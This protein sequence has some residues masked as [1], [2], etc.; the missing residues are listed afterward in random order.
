MGDISRLKDMILRART[1][2]ERLRLKKE[3]L[4]VKPTG[5]FTVGSAPIIE[6]TSVASKP[7]PIQQI[8]ED[9]RKKLA[10]HVILQ[11][12]RDYKQNKERKRDKEIKTKALPAVMDRVIDE[13]LF[14]RPAHRPK[15][16]T[17]EELLSRK[18][19]DEELTKTREHERQ[20]RHQ[21][22]TKK[23]MA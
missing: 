7:S 21:R 3:L 9:G 22:R 11:H 19:Y 4:R 12:Y 14:P 5:H 18:V 17:K 2:D 16:T 8:M 10:G 23:M 6:T 1:E 20:T 13:Q 15:G